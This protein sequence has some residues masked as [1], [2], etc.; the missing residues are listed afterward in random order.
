VGTQIHFRKEVGGF[1]T[2]KGGGNFISIRKT[3]RET[4]GKK[5]GPKK[6]K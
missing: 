1:C 3:Q 6:E 2:A 4:F 5:G